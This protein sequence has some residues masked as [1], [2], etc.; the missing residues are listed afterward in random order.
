MKAADN[1]K[2]TALVTK[3]KQESIAKQYVFIFD[4]CLLKH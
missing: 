3:R 1:D 2:V 4:P